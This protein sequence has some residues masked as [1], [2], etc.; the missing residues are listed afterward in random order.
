MAASG[1]GL[2]WS[3]NSGE[4]ATDPKRPLLLLE[5]TP[6]VDPLLELDDEPE[7]MERDN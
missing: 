4:A 6:S 3:S 5:L 2:L 7:S 1:R